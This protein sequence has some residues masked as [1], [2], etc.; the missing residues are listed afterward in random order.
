VRAGNRVEPVALRYD[1]SK[2]NFSWVNEM[3]FF[4][5]IFYSVFVVARYVSKTNAVYVS[6]A[7]RAVWSSQFV[8]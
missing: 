2:C 4:K 1:L 5:T 3:Y 6:H 7:D 8:N